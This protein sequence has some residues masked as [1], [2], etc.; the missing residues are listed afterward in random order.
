M[1]ISFLLVFRLKASHTHA[2]AYKKRQ[3]AFY[4][5]APSVTSRSDKGL[6]LCVLRPLGC[7]WN[8]RCPLCF[9][10]CNNKKK[11]NTLGFFYFLFKDSAPPSVVI[12][13]PCCHRGRRPAISSTLGTPSEAMSSLR[14]A[15]RWHGIYGFWSRPSFIICLHLKYPITAITT[16]SPYSEALKGMSL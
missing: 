4:S 14:L 1:L 9:S 7:R 8:P 15:V 13:T 10:K 5:S 2:C 11:N 3:I 12:V 16:Y 6:L